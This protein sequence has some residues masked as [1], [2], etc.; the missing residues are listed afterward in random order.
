M[1][2]IYGLKSCG[3]CARAVKLLHEKSVQFSYYPLDHEQGILEY[4][5]TCYDQ[6]TVPIIVQSTNGEEIKYIRSR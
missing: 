5:K 2:I 6:K 4:M 1:Y 3:Y